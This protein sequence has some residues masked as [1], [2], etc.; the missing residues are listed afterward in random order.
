[1]PWWV[2]FGGIALLGTLAWGG[3]LAAPWLPLP[4]HEVERLLALAHPVRDELICD[5]GCGD[6]RVLVHAARRYG[7]RGVGYE[8]ALLPYLLAWCRIVVTRRR[9]QVYVAYRNFFNQPLGRYSLV[10]A[11][12]TPRA[13]L[14]L[15]PKLARELRPG[16]RIVSYAFPIPGW[17]P[18]AVS[19][20]NPT[21]VAIY[22]Y[23]VVADPAATS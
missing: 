19:K 8:V 20:P 14:K 18:S 12:L 13:M 9:G 17:Q 23:D 22:R 2:T 6:G 5:L 15:A 7:A 1:M 11:F 4:R 21:T 16:A 3:V 10:T